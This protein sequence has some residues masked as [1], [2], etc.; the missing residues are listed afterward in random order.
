MFLT[1]TGPKKG[2]RYLFAEVDE[3]PEFLNK[4][5]YPSLNGLRAMSIIMVVFFHMRP[6]DNWAYKHF[7]AGDL[8]VDIFFVISGFLIT[9]LCLKEKVKTSDIN[10]KSFYTRRVLRI[11]PVAYLYLAFIIALNAIQNLNIP[12]IY[13]MA[14]GLFIANFSVF[15]KYQHR[16]VAQYWSLAVEE[17]FYLIFPFLL[18]K[19]FKVYLSLILFIV[20]VLPLV[21]YVQE[22]IPAFNT[23]VLYF[24]I[25]FF[26][27][28]QGIAVGSLLAV[29][30]FKGYINPVNHTVTRTLINIAAFALMICLEFD[31]FFSFKAIALNLLISIL[32]AL[33]IFVNVTPGK[34]IFFRIL[35]NAAMNKIG[36]LSYSIYIWHMLFIVPN[37]HLPRVLYLFPYN[38]GLILIMAFISYYGYERYF[39]KLK[40]RFTKTKGLSTPTSPPA[41]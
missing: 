5:Y 39:L 6:A 35:N 18:K 26:A 10:L 32:I 34:D 29:L 20:F 30:A 3:V 4:G 21:L 33:I 38:V 40:E 22:K 8:G 31:P 24:I 36:V 13:I 1:N 15:N 23:G 14:A 17:Q 11:L 25:H 9:T 16:Y 41:P 2:M 28:F 37:P 27:K 19:S 12:H 7:F